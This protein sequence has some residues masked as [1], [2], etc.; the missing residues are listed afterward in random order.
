MKLTRAVKEKTGVDLDIIS[1][2]TEA[3]MSY[4]GVV[5]T[6]NVE[7][8]VIFDL[9]GGSTEVIL[10]R[11]RKLI[12]SVSLPIGCVNLTKQSRQGSMRGREDMKTMQKL[13]AEQMKKRLG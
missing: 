4:V 9:G 12:D 10:V 11:K 5:N 1:G 6:I 8:A 7:D 13:I 2:K 3:F